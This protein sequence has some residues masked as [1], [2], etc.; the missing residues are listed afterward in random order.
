MK[1]FLDENFPKAAKALLHKAGHE[2]VDV[3]GTDREGST[4][5]LH[6]GATI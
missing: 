4:R 3:R 1:F 6:K 2:V 5:Q